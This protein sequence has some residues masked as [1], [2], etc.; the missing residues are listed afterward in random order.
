VA[1][2][3]GVSLVV[4]ALGLERLADEAASEQ[5][6][7]RVLSTPVL[8]LR[9]APSVL[10]EALA[11]ARLRD[12]LAAVISLMPAEVC[13]SVRGSDGSTF[14]HRP[15]ASMVPASTQKLLTA[16]AALLELGPD[17]RFRTPVLVTAG[18]VEGVLAGD[19]HLVGGG[20]PVLH[21]A[22]YLARFPRP[23]VHTD[24]GVLADA[25]VASGVRRVLGTVVGDEARYDSQRY[26]PQWPDRYLVQNQSG[27]LSALAVNDGFAGFPGSVDAPGP[28]TPAGDPPANAAAV[29][30]RLLRE[31]GVEIGGPARAGEVPEGAVEL[32][33]VESPPLREILQQLLAD[34]DNE[35]GE[36]LLKE[37]GLS[38][39]GQ[40]STP[41]GATALRSI[42][43]ADGVDL[44]GT[45]I[46]DG[47]GLALENRLGCPLLVELLDRDGT[48]P[49]VRAALAVAGE[50]GTLAERYRGTDIAGRLRAKTGSLRSVVALAGT[51]G[52]PTVEWTFAVVANGAGGST[53][54]PEAFAGQ[55]ALV[56]ALAAHPREA[57]PG[58]PAP[59]PP[60]PRQGAARAQ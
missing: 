38:A 43:E 11:L 36:L 27:P 54:P 24:L 53:L 37:I 44:H 35:T 5:P 3:A 32:A 25:V 58:I 47:S 59:A 55:A 42:L 23:R 15:D 41:A 34:S 39:L 18:P 21:T 20:D 13:V 49:V 48:G 19:L 14:E 7:E 10:A 16:T 60:Q 28:L 29:L 2:V 30:A 4:S 6:S 17:H 40:G 51:V 26:V 12:D 31:R 8:S 22:D 1:A 33:A 46:V 56:E 50:T 45:E 57:D 9:R 52:T